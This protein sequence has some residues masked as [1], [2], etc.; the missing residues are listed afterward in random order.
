M[1]KMAGVPDQ[2]C[3]NTSALAGGKFKTELL[4]YNNAYCSWL[5]QATPGR[6]SFGTHTLRW[7]KGAMQISSIG[8]PLEVPFQP[9]QGSMARRHGI[10][11]RFDTELGDAKHFQTFYHQRFKIL[12]ILH[13]LGH[14]RMTR[15][16]LYQRIYVLCVL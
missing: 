3:E 16:L 15:L 4:A 2:Q 8:H 5:F 11:L 14:S 6:L 13:V 7:L 12:R 10:E 1:H 9:L